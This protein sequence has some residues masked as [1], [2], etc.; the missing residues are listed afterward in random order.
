MSE[1]L[2][3]EHDEI[4][5]RGLLS[6]AHTTSVVLWVVVLIQRRLALCY[7]VIHAFIQDIQFNNARKPGCLPAPRVGCPRICHCSVS[8]PIKD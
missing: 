1:C 4:R 3:G 6:S 5:V 8:F 7:V 2:L